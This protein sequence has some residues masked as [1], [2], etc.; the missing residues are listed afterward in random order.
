MIPVE[1]AGPD[2]AVSCEWI[3]LAMVAGVGFFAIPGATVAVIA[4]QESGRRLWVWLPVGAVF[5][6][7]PTSASASR[8]SWFRTP[9][10][11]SWSRTPSRNRTSSTPT[12]GTSRGS[13]SHPRCAPPGAGMLPEARTGVSGC[14]SC[15]ALCS[16]NSR[17]WSC[18]CGHSIT[19]HLRIPARPPQKRRASVSGS[20]GRDSRLET[21]ARLLEP[22]A[23][24]GARRASRGS[25][26]ASAPPTRPPA[27]RGWRAGGAAA[28]GRGCT[29]RRRRCRSRVRPGRSRSAG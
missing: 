29:R 10:R 14:G 19:T 9:S 22:G 20:A 4:A 23:R 21:R 5:P 11:L 8:L 2:D 6:L 24:G 25:A 15:W 17:C 12:S 28:A 1:C 27:P 26:V 16:S 18:S 13:R 7:E 3:A